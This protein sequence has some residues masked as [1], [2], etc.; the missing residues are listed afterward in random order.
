MENTLLRD[1]LQV[2]V[3]LWQM[4]FQDCPWSE[5][6]QK[7]R[8]AQ[9]ILAENAEYLLFYSKKEKDKGKAA[10]AFNAVA[11]GIAILSFVPGGVE[12][13]GQRWIGEL[14]SQ[15]TK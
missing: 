5:L 4:E 10:A 2:A 8:E 11:K 13:F 6:Q 15:V 7:I 9:E 12:L 14:K 3:P 1:T